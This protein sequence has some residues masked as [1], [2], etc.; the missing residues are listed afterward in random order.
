MFWRSDQDANLNYF[1]EDMRAQEIARCQEG[2][3]K[4]QAA[5]VAT[6]EAP[7]QNI[8]ILPLAL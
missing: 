2:L 3:A 8:E 4:D 6:K 1:P 7:D 5:E